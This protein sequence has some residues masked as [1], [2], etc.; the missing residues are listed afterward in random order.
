MEQV[1]RTS[2]DP[3]LMLGKSDLDRYLDILYT[4]YG[5][6]K[7]RRIQEARYKALMELVDTISV[8]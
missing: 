6:Q 8:A 1:N 2:R 4:S 5:S 3:G 7:H